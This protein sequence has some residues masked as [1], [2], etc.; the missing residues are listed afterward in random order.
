M[1]TCCGCSR[2]DC[3]AECPEPCSGSVTC[4]CKH[5]AALAARK[6]VP[7]SPTLSSGMVGAKAH[8]MTHLGVA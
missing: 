1:G 2:A 4:A 3:R 5:T 6:V 7:F 8:S